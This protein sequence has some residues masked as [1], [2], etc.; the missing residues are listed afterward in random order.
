MSLSPQLIHPGPT[1]IRI[2]IHTHTHTHTHTL[3]KKSPR[4]AN[5]NQHCRFRLSF[6]FL[7]SSLAFCF[8]CFVVVFWSSHIR[9]RKKTN[10]KE[11][12]S[13]PIDN[14]N[15][16]KTNKQAQ[17]HKKKQTNKQ[18]KQ[19]KT[20]GHGP[21]FEHTIVFTRVC[22]CLQG[23]AMCTHRMETGQSVSCATWPRPW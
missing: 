7:G 16:T 11:A 20:K 14:K 12:K 19:N 3:K 17:K 21:R 8:V 2:H 4:N 10:K 13:L 6:R 18:T 22:V 9:H 23:R 15:K 1:Y 5:T